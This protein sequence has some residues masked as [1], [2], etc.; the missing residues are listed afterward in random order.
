M[1]LP[2]GIGASG[3]A[4]AVKP[5]FRR[6]RRSAPAATPPA[7][8]R[9]GRR[10]TQE[11]KPPAIRH[12]SRRPCRWRESRPAHR[13]ASARWN[14]ANPHRTEAADET[15][16]PSTGSVVSD[17]I[18]P[19][20]CAAPPAPATMTFRPAAFAVRANSVETIGRPVGGDDAGIRFDAEFG[21]NVPG[22]LHRLP[23]GLAS[24]DDGHRRR[25]CYPWSCGDPSWRKRRN[26]RPDRGGRQ[27]IMAAGNGNARDCQAIM[28]GSSSLSSRLIWSRRA[29][30]RFLRRCMRS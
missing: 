8:H 21:Q 14:A 9:S 5:A 28:S 4:A 27:P 22:F 19:G 17:A 11:W 24:H 1:T 15:G 29:S 2:G 25:R 7:P 18:M 26:Y 3:P 13:P 12:S 20:R 30:F 10:S 23:V 6:R 16:T